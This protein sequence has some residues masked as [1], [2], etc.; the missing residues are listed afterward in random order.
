MIRI[1]IASHKREKIICDKTLKFLNQTCQFKTNIYIFVPNE[2]ITNYKKELGRYDFTNLN[3]IFIDS[4]NTLSAKMNF[5]IND[6]FEH[7]D[8]IIYL[9]DDI[10]SIQNLVEFNNKK[11]LTNILDMTKFINR[12]YDILIEND[13]KIFGIYPVYNSYFMHFKNTTCFKFLIN[14]FWGFIVN[15]HKSI[16]I[17]TECK[18]DYEKSIIFYKEYGKMLRFNHI[19]CKTNNYKTIGGLDHKNRYDKEEESA[20][21]LLITYPDY[22]SIKNCKS[23][24]K[25]IRLKKN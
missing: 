10:D 19:V 17:N 4:P 15:K 9:E 25:Q 21:Y 18:S 22:C 13:L 12:T 20:D 3:I 14:H 23:E 7:N 5:V 8:F 2:Q 24:F 6:Y 11:H 1:C 16:I